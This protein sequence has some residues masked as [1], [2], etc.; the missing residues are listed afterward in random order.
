MFTAPA[1]VAESA[2]KKTAPKPKIV[3]GKVHVTQTKGENPSIQTIKLPVLEN[4]TAKNRKAFKKQANSLLEASLWK[5]NRARGGYCKN[6]DVATFNASPAYKGVY[7]NRYASVSMEF[8][9]YACGATV[10]SEMKSFTLD[11]TTG[12]T[13]GIKRFVAQDDT[14]TKVAVVL[15]FARA[16]NDCIGYLIPSAK[17]YKMG[18]MPRPAAWD[19]SSKG[20]R[21]H[22]EKYSIGGGA[23]GLP[24]VLLPWTDVTTAKSI[25]G[26]VK[27]RIYVNGIKYNKRGGYY[28]GTILATSVQGR[29][30]TLYESGFSPNSG[31]CYHGL[32]NGK[33]AAVIQDRGGDEIGKIKL[34]L[35]GSSSNPKVKW[36]NSGTHEATAKE[37][38][39]IKKVTGKNMTARKQCGA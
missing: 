35:K 1:K 31:G 26:P 37:L 12:K 32:H 27:N 23:C 9:I 4:A 22:Y 14:T 28:D 17:P 20:I 39:I 2:L 29:K 3:T 7:K 21:F 18:F 6:G 11:L 25:S 30:I 34:P 19:V 13:V 5:F 24:N 33:T 38:K 10:S 8:D 36:D 15:N 16:E